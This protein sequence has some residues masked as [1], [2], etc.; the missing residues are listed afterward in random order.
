MRK[1]T[2]TKNTRRK[3]FKKRAEINKAVELVRPLTAANIPVYAVLGN[4]DYAMM[5]RD[6]VKLEWLAEEVSKSL[7]A[8]GVEVL[9][10]EA[11]PLPLPENRARTQ[12]GEDGKAPLYVVGV[13]DKFARNDNP[14]LALSRVPKETPRLALMH[15]PDSFAV[16]PAGTAP[17]ALA[18]HTHGGQIRLPFTPEWSWMFLV[19]ADEVYADGWIDGYGQSGNRLY[20]NRGIGFS[21]VPIRINCQPEVTLFTLR[22]A[23]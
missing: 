14:A 5:T 16:F 13:G 17:L 7:E 22:R 20:V 10:N 3:N 21:L 6:D 15:N 12:G 4:H 18:G 11:A 2:C 23:K 1:K 9:D 19:S 8:A